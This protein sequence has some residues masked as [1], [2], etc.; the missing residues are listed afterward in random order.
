MHTAIHPRAIALLAFFLI[1]LPLTQGQA[2]GTPVYPEGRGARPLAALA[3]SAKALRESGTLLSMEKVKEQSKRTTCELTLPPVSTQKLTSRELWQRARDSH[4]RVGWLYLCKDCDK[5]HLNL[6]GGY[7]ITADTVATCAHVTAPLE[8]MR[9]GYLVAADEEEN[10]LAISE[11]LASNRALDAA[12][13]RI[14]DG[15]LTP[16]PLGQDVV[17]GDTVVCFSD[18]MGRRGYYSQGMVNRFVKRPFLKKREVEP[19][20]SGTTL[21]SSSGASGKKAPAPESPIWME[22]STDWAP[23]SSGSAV[24]DVY[25]NSVAHV[26]EIE[27]ILEDAQPNAKRTEARS[28]GTLMIFHDAITVGSVLNLIKPLPTPRP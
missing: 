10:L 4:I 1:P 2:P 24:L 27:P 17:P 15:H 13:V 7:A 19:A 14:K 26:S 22:V 16:L 21:T 6:S 12:I 11:V 28:R 3:R 20:E 23:G 5:W 9:E 18:P 8:D 25:G